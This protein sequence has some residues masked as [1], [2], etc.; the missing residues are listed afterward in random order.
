MVTAP[1]TAANLFTHAN[2]IALIVQSLETRSDSDNDNHR[3]VFRFE[4]RRYRL[5]FG[6]PVEKGNPT[7]IHLIDTNTYL[8]KGI[9]YR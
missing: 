1:S 3:R 7:P 2:A 9:L 8:E 5:R 4:P 6:V